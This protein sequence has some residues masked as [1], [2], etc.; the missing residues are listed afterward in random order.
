MGRIIPVNESTGRMVCDFCHMVID[1]GRT[2][3][4]IREGKAQGLYHGRRCYEAALAHYEE[5]EGNL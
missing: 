3:T 1:K 4:Q 2:A 5:L